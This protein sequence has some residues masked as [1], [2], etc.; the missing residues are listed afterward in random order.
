M[1]I[2]RINDKSFANFPNFLTMTSLALSGSIVE[3]S[4]SQNGSITLVLLFIAFPV[5]KQEN[6]KN[7]SDQI[8]R[9]Y[10]S[11]LGPFP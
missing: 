6:S 9:I 4:I 8:W 5:L 10:H 2:F 1:M 11:I 3:S 7:N